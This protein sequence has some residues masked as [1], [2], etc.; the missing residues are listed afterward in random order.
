[1]ITTTK[2]AKTVKQ[3]AADLVSENGGQ[4]RV[5]LRSPSAKV[6]VDLSGKPHYDKVAQKSFPT[7]HTK[8]S[9]RNFTAPRQPA[10]NTGQATYRNA[11]QQDIRLVR[12]YLES[13]K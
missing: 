8:V 2:T 11:T 9:P 5:T 7:P 1:V 3:Q 6:E 13:Q 12:K 10:Y 4:N